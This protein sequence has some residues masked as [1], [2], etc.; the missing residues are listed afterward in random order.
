MK[1][2]ILLCFVSLM[3][4]AS[5]AQKSW[6]LSVQTYTFHHYSF[7]QAVEKADSLGIK[8]LEVYPGQKVGGDFPGEFTY[9]MSKEDRGKIKSFL[10]YRGIKIVAIGVV[11]KYYYNK[12]NLEKFFQ[13]AKDMGISYITAEPEWQDLDEFNRLAGK[14]KVKVALHCHPKP[15]SHYWN[16]DSMLVAIQGRSNIG[17]WPDIGHWVRSGINVQDGLKKLEGKIWGMHLKDI[18]EFGKLDAADT[19]LG[20]GICDIPAV[21]QELKRQKFKGV[22]SLEYE[23]NPTHNMQELQQCV[24]FYLHE[25]GKLE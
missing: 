8:N 11:D 12:D 16:P 22:L 13:F 15:E 18:R 3:A 23:S 1:R 5:F 7:L 4:A 9:T 25:L 14:Y 21:L 17:A 6:R 24:L 2:I 10:E 19:I 20:K